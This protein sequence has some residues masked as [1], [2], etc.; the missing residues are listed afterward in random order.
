ML[1][2]CIDWCWH[3]INESEMYVLGPIYSI[4][5]EHKAA[6]TVST[7]KNRSVDGM[8]YVHSY[9]L[10]WEASVAAKC[11]T[12]AKIKQGIPAIVVVRKGLKI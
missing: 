5:V 12:H 1:S 2:Q 8:L 7:F 6:N 9:L 11:H 3:E 10:T 4:Q